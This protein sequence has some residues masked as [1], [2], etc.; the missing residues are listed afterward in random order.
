MTALLTAHLEKITFLVV[1]CF[2]CSTSKH[3]RGG[4][5]GQAGLEL[6]C[7]ETV[8]LLVDLW[9]HIFVKELCLVTDLGLQ[10]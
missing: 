3:P 10:L 7:N 8:I 2:V 9:T 5:G 4:G 1:F 6:K